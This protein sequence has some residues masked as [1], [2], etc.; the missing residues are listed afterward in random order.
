MENVSIKKLLFIDGL[1]ALLSAFLLGVV[2]VGLESYFGIPKSTL[3][4]LAV[5]PCV[6]AIYDFYCYFRIRDKHWMYLRVI[7]IA[8]IL[9]ACLSLVLAFSHF[10][11]ITV[12]GWVYIIVEIIIVVSLALYELW[13]VNKSI[14][15][16]DGH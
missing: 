12:Y 15:T 1:G 11:V 8:N 6:F 7:A 16:D 14:V 13:V 4:V 2:L 3:Y 9:Y 10:E 5:I